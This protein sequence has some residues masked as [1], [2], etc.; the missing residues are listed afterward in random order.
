MMGIEPTNPLGHNQV[1][2]Q[3]SYIR[4]WE[5]STHSRRAWQAFYAVFAA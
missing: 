2:Y 4:R 3:L 1:L 5:L